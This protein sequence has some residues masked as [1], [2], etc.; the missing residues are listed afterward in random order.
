MVENK[1]KNFISA[2]VYLRNA[3]QETAWF[4]TQLNQALAAL[5]EQYEII[6]V[7]DASTD[8]CAETASGLG[9][10]C[11]FSVVRMSFY[12]GVELA[13]N[14]GVDFAIGD[15]VYEF[16]GCHVEYDFGIVGELYFQCLKGYD[17]VSARSTK[18]A[19]GANIFYKLYNLGVDPRRKLGD[20]IIHILSRRAINRVHAMSKTVP[21]RKALYANSGLKT[22]VL[23]CTPR[24]GVQMPQPPLRER[25]SQT[26]ALDAIILFTDMAYRAAIFMSALMIFATVAIGLYVLTVYLS[27]HPV[28]GFTPLMLVMT[29][30]FFFVF[31]IFAVIIKYLAVI[32]D[33]VFKK[34]T[35]MVESVE[36]IAGK[37]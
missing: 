37:N 2:V 29:G 34:K 25:C 31:A 3:Q 35:Y 27:Q 15:F 1:E 9:L 21:Y 10:G 32:L 36:K 23:A 7:D 14:A 19:W 5:F 18:T 16:D 11:M 12:H 20:D 6:C 8:G 13:L 4:L 17:I 33:L 30:G 26:T 24:K 22:A 28:P